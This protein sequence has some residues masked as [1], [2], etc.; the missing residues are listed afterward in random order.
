M[1]SDPSL[2]LLTL[3]EQID[4]CRARPVLSGI[5]VPTALSQLTVALAD[6]QV[7]TQHAA[8]TAGRLLAEPSA[9]ARERAAAEAF[10]EAA[11]GTAAAGALLAR[12]IRQS[13]ASALR[14]TL[15]NNRARLGRLRLRLE[16]ADT[17]ARVCTA[18]AD[19][20]LATRRA[21][22]SLPVDTPH[23]RAPEQL[24]TL[25]A[26]RRSPLPG[27][28]APTSLGVLASAAPPPLATVLPFR[29]R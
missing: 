29:R 20:A 16:G 6:L 23:N 2:E 1:P 19:A 7:I 11:S 24:R 15:P 8:D 10:A 4:A 5:V 22:T 12:A 28:A 26:L 14:Q 21:A 17:G 9:S 18:L 27:P 25:A 3:A 13:A